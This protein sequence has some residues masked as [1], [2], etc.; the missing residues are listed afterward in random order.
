MPG[1]ILNVG[2]SGAIHL[3]NEIKKKL[4]IKKEIY[5][6][7]IG[8]KLVIIPMRDL[9]EILEDSIVELSFDEVEKISERSSER[10]CLLIHPS[11]FPSSDRCWIQ[12]NTQKRHN[13][14]ATESDRIQIHSF[15]NGK[16][17][18]KQEIP[19]STLQRLLFSQ[20]TE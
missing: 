6:E 18:W 14:L 16:E 15:E 8:N 11:Y 19:R 7:V 13:H 20:D 5:A 17:N 4:K 3:T 10:I 2:G 1:Y 9:D 12:R